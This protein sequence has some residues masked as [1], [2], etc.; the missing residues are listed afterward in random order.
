MKPEDILNSLG[1]V[2]DGMICHAKERARTQWKKWLAAAACLCVCLFGGILWMLPHGTGRTIFV[3]PVTVG[4][5]VYYTAPEQHRWF[6]RTKPYSC[7]YDRSRGTSIRLDHTGDFRQTG[8]GPVL[9]S[10]GNLYLAEGAELTKLGTLPVGE[11][12]EDRLLDLLDGVAYWV[13]TMADTVDAAL[14]GTNLQ[15]GET[16]CLDTVPHGMMGDG[17]IRGNTLFY[18][19]KDFDTGEQQIR[20][21]NCETG[22][23]AVLDTFRSEENQ[24]FFME[25][26]MVLQRTDGL[27]SMSYEGGTPEFLSALT[28]YNASVDEYDGTLYYAAS[29]P[30]EAYSREA[31]VSV[32]YETK[33]Q[34]EVTS[35]TSGGWSEF[36]Y[37]ELAVC[38][39]GYYFTDPQNGFFFHS[40]A[41]GTN[42]QIAK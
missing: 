28:P 23:Q 38:G 4:E 19:A 36:T 18:V 30:T 26:R 22:E 15:T 35:L 20:T 6:Y 9:L 34:R 14:Y 10:Q 21:R 3:R 37:V 27:W 31:L 5:D 1:E 2:E 13:E 11:Q 33:K 24:V 7:F 41:N 17:V 29:I 32:D 8:I 12:T 39:D 16:A 42:L 25:D 40:F